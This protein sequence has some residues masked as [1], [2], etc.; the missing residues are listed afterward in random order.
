MKRN[1]EES[2]TRQKKQTKQRTKEQRK[3][4]NSIVTSLKD[5][6]LNYMK[7]SKRRKMKSE[8]LDAAK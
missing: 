8:K 7:Q 6:L 2:I 1:V 5:D 3:P 4:W